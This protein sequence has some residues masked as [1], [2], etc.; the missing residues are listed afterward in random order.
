[1]RASFRNRAMRFKIG[2]L[3]SGDEVREAPAIPA[4]QS[5]FPVGCDALELPVRHGRR[6]TPFIRVLGAEAWRASRDR[7]GVRGRIISG[8][9]KPA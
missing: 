6:H 7:N 2:Q 3:G 9:R 4:G 8:T 5:G 1:M